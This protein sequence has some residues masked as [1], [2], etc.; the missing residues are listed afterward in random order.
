MGN[1]LIRVS[2]HI[3]VGTLSQRAP[4]SQR[5][6]VHARVV[7]HRPSKSKDAVGRFLSLRR[8]SVF[9]PIDTPY[10][11]NRCYCSI[12]RKTGGG[13]GYAINIMGRADTLKITGEENVSVYRSARNDGMITRRTVS[14]SEDRYFCCKCG[15][16]LWIQGTDYPD[17]VYPFASA[18]ERLPEPPEITHLMLNEKAPWVRLHVTDHDAR[19]DNIPIMVSKTGISNADCSISRRCQKSLIRRSQIQ[20]GTGSDPGGNN[21]RN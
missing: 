1:N 9:R 3:S 11:F 6:R 13:G 16:A 20:P 15:S 5:I 19:F 4:S 2:N 18:V 21:H 7:Y 17:F 10:P 14:E 8:R 12:C